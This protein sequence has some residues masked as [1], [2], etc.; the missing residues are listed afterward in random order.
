MSADPSPEIYSLPLFPLKL[1][2]F[3]QLMLQLHIFE[4]RYK[5]MITTC[6][7]RNQPFGVV[8]IREAE[9]MG[10]PAVPHEVGCVAR[11]LAV[12]HLEEGRMNLLIAGEKRFRILEY[13]EADLPYLIGTVE[14]LEDAPLA[15]KRQKSLHPE[16]KA[17]FE[18]Y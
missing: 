15:N 3:P 11:I 17:L 12:K 2:L 7:E 5:A 10:A 6:I 9:E 13:G 4:D 8:L 14:T 1:V 16:L 18:R